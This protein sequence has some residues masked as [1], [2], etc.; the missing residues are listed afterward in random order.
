[1]VLE[2]KIVRL[3]IIYLAII[4]LMKVIKNDNDCSFDELGIGQTNL[5]AL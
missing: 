4:S 3:F 2:I 5:S 1:M